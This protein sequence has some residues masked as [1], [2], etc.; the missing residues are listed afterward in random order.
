MSLIEH[1]NATTPREEKRYDTDSK[2]RKYEETKEVE[3]D[4]RP[5]S[6]RV[7]R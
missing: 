1:D 7:G 2:K 4:R 5:F 6:I 3:L